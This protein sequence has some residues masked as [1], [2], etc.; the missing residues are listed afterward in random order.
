MNASAAEVMEFSCGDDA[1][2]Q[3]A[4]CENGHN[5]TAF[6]NGTAGVMSQPCP[7][8]TSTAVC[9]SIGRDNSP[10]VVV[11]YTATNITCQCELNSVSNSQRR[12]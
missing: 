9:K 10:C 12:L 2:N 1:D 8:E 11:T 5:V 7:V 4:M 6:C 3:T